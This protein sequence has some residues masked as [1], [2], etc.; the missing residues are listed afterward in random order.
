MT[1]I[2]LSYNFETEQELRDH[3]AG[4]SRAEAPA[5]AV[6]EAEPEDVTPAGEVPVT[7]DVDGDGMPYDIRVHSDPRSFSADG[8]WRAKR[9]QAEAAKAARA[10]FKAQGGT[11]VAPVIAAAPAA[12]VMPGM[13][14][15][16][17]LP[18]MPVA[19]PDPITYD[20]LFEKV[21]GMITR[22][23]IKPEQFGPLYAKCGITDPTVL[24]T[25][26][27]LRAAL[28]GELCAIEP[29]LA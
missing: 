14:V 23:A 26:E 7:A 9:G 4:A 2:V 19:A 22:A 20:R 1:K 24:E 11:V 5:T 6:R 13:P 21:T 3:L 15:A 17:G 25:N 28:F 12:P 8:L 27:S 16:A 18:G 29:E 10:A